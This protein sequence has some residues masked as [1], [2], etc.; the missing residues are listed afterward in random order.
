MENETLDFLY[1]RSRNDV[2]HLVLSLSDSQ[3]MCVLNQHC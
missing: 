1:F 2:I 3:E